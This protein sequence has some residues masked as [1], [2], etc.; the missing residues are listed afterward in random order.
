MIISS[1]KTLHS[2]SLNQRMEINKWEI[3]MWCQ[4]MK[5][6]LQICLEDIYES[7]FT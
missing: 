1:T 2:L 6:D 3:K 4:L 5:E 7:K